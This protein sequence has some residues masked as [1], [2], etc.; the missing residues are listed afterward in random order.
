[1]FLLQSGPTLEQRFESYYNYCNLFNYILSKNSF[2]FWGWGGGELPR[3]S[4]SVSVEKQNKLCRYDVAFRRL[5]QWWNISGFLSLGSAW[6]WN[7]FLSVCT[8]KFCHVQSWVRICAY[9]Q[10]FHC[11][12]SPCGILTVGVSIAAFFMLCSV[13]HFSK[14]TQTRILS[15][16]K[17]DHKKALQW[18]MDHWSDEEV[19]SYLCTISFH[20]PAF[21]SWAW[22]LAWG[23][24]VVGMWLCK[25][26]YK[27]CHC[28]C[29]QMLMAQCL[30]NCPTSGCGTSLMS[31]SI[32]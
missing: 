3:N 2:S 4:V 16:R 25:F 7:S 17:S 27:T 19:S 30:W 24:Y 20:L 5:W 22:T 15:R 13:H 12:F 6:H 10:L 28:G 8:C 21:L 29:V 11:H 32:R 18:Y 26:F 14:R 23:K 9:L 31:S 1:M